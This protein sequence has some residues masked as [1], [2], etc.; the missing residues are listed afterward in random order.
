MIPTMTPQK[1][2]SEEEAIS[3]KFLHVCNRC[4]RRFLNE[5]SLKIHSNHPTLCTNDPLIQRPRGAI[6][7]VQL[8]A[9]RKKDKLLVHGAPNMQVND[10]IIGTVTSFNYLGHLLTADDDMYAP[11]QDPYNKAG[12]THRSLYKAVHSKD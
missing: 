9:K 5:A 3:M 10:T 11:I 7:A 1:N 6:K 12:N 8:A 2:I 4:N